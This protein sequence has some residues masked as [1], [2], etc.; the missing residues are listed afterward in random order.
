[1]IKPGWLKKKNI[2]G[3]SLNEIY[4]AVPYKNETVVV[5]K[6]SQGMVLDIPLRKPKGG[7]KFLALI[8]PLSD[9]HRIFLDR[10]GSLIYD[11]LNGQAN[12][13]QLIREFALEHRLGLIESRELVVNFLKKLLKRGAVVVA[14]EKKTNE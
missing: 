4:N 3:L 8:M 10:I 2:E 12:V 6:V 14:L 11:K 13:E 7:W 5:T 9:Q 1:M